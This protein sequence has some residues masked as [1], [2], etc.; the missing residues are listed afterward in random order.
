M[1][2]ATQTLAAELIDAMPAT[3]GPIPAP[4]LGADGKP[5]LNAAGTVKRKRGRPS[6]ARSAPPPR[7]AA[8]D[9]QI[10]DADPAADADAAGADAGQLEAAAVTC[11]L[12]WEGLGLMV[13]GEAG[14]FE[15]DA[16]R[17]HITASL[18]A[19]LAAKGLTDIPPG[20]A[21][22]IAATG[23]LGARLHRPTVTE[24]LAM[25]F[26]WARRKLGF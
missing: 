1:K 13:L 22:A 19:Y 10:F 8:I 21:L 6:K 3:P 5:Q 25:M 23:Y 16:E 2:D 4:E 9:P 17:E 11:A 20:V 12:A 24:R 26:A 14:K 15:S 18:R 7:P